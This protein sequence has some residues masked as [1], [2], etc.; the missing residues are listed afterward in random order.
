V[1]TRSYKSQTYIE[2]N[3]CTLKLV[4]ELNKVPLTVYLHSVLDAPIPQS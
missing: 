2:E 4:V 1:S 3:H